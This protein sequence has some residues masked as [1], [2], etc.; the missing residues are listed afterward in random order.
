M[1]GA[2]SGQRLRPLI[3]PLIETAGTHSGIP[4]VQFLANVEAFLQV[5]GCAGFEGLPAQGLVAPV[6][7]GPGLVELPLAVFRQREQGAAL[8]EYRVDQLG[9]DAMPGHVEKAAVLAGPVQLVGQPCPTVRGGGI[10]QGHIDDGQ[11]RWPGRSLGC[12]GGCHGA[13]SFAGWMS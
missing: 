4:L 7:G 1:T 13:F 3:G 5:R 2:K 11:G 10:E 9:R 12:L 6:G 8:P